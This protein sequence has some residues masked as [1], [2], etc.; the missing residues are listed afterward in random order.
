MAITTTSIFVPNVGEQ[1]MLKDVLTSQAWRLGL[2]KT[3]ITPDGNTVFSTMTEL[4]AESGGYQTK[5]L[6]NVIATDA[7]TADKWYVYTNANGK[8]EAQYGAAD[9]PQEWTFNAADVANS[10][11]A[12]GILMWSLTIAF[13][14][15]DAAEIKVGDTVASAVGGETAIVTGIRLGSGAWG[16]DAAGTLCLKTQSG[17]FQAGE[18]NVSAVGLADIAGDTD[19][20][21]ILA[22]LFSTAQVIETVGQKIKVTPKITMASA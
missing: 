8:A 16:V 4:D 18:L 7:L 15:G 17:V 11:T 3:Q 19:K 1:E 22:G 10:D 21:L 12:Y 9:A 20:K 2:Y 5:D 6:A 13:T 14:G